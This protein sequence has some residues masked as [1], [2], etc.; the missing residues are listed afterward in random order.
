MDNTKGQNVMGESLLKAV[1]AAVLGVVLGWAGN[2][3]TLSG[4][5]DAIEK[6]LAR[7]EAK[8]EARV[9]T[10]VAQAAPAQ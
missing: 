8:V 6:T 2:A 1:G 3:L 7:I 4:R 5:V 10:Q 9:P